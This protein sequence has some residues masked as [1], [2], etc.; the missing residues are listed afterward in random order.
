MLKEIG[1]RARKDIE[2]LLGIKVNLQLWVKIKSDW[3]NK[4]RELKDLGYQ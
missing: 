3:R 1:K 4:Q 2:D